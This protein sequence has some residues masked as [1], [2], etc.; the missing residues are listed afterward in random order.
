[1]RSL[2]HTCTSTNIWTHIAH[3]HE[4]TKTRT[5]THTHSHTHPW[6]HKYART[7]THPWAQE[8]K[9]SLKNRLNR[10]WEVEWVT[11]KPSD[12]ETQPLPKKYLTPPTPE[13]ELTGARG[14][15]GCYPAS[16]SN[17]EQKQSPINTSVFG[18]S[19]YVLLPQL[20]L[21]PLLLLLLLCT[22]ELWLIFR[23]ALIW[24]TVGTLQ[25]S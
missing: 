17:L 25:S 12:Q 3:T 10:T 15:G 5:H 7:H 6:A 14:E 24:V 22:L 19:C 13:P 21:L 11:L 16:N 4:L 20:L 1:M 18:S 9:F 23:E 8:Y 2:T